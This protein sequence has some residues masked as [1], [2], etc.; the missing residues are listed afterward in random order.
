MYVEQM[1]TNCLAEAAYWVES[2]G[3]AV[4]ID[5]IRETAPYLAKAKERGVTIKYIFET[6]FHA[7]F[8]SGHI[9]LSKSTGAEIV[10][11]PGADPKYPVHVAKDNEEFQVGQVKIRALHTPGHTP[12]SSCYLLIDEKGNEHAVFTGDTLFVG[13]VGRPDLLDGKMSKEE[14]AGMMFDSLKNKLKP[15][16]DDVLMYPGHGP[17]S[18]CGKNIGTETWS[19]IGQQKKTNYAMKI[20][21]RDEFIKAVTAGLSAPPQYFFKDAM[22]NKTGYESIDH[23]MDRNVTPID[24]LK[25]KAAVEAGALV[26]DTRHQDEFEKGFIPGST[27]IGLDGTYAVWVGTLIDI[28]TKLVIVA[29]PGKEKEAILRLA[30]VG[31][32]NV[33]GYLEGGI[34]AWKKANLPVDSVKSIDPNVFASEMNKPQHEAVLDVRR[35]GEWNSGHAE[36]AMHVCLSNFA[37]E[38]GTNPIDTNKPYFVHCAGGYRS[39]IAISLLKQKGY[40]NL[41][42]VRGGWRVLEKMEFPKVVPQ[43][44]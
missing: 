7:D 20:T 21:D 40:T 17:G 19:T 44:A 1:Y 11:G 36:G 35:A 24:A 27:F 3:E 13:D 32:E 25:V 14:L 15:L 41:I 31:Y 38:N 8:V 30:R 26:L 34:D 18:A 37:K 28:N 16:A 23:V 2:N 4:V 12:E 5:P 22:I 42:N 29:A 9:D 10:Y 43:P 6:H 39:M 33:L